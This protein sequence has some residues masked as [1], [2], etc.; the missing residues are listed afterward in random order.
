MVKKTSVTLPGFE[1][2]IKGTIPKLLI[3]SGTHGDEFE[4]IDLVQS[5]LKKYETMLP[6]FIYVPKVSPSAV[7]LKTR[8]TANGHDINRNFFSNSKDPEVVENIKL[9]K[10]HKFELMV[11]F[12][13]D[14]VSEDFYIYEQSFIPGDNKKIIDFNLQLKENG[15][16][17]LNGIDDPD[18]PSLGY[19]FVEGYRKFVAKKDEKNTGGHTTTWALTEGIIKQAL[20]P[21]IPGRLSLDR[22]RLIV[23]TF[24]EEVLIS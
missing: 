8:F 18:D 5:A 3:H 14:P 2:F 10:G 23:E 4:V 15:V 13:E 9:I 7:K 19:Q 12:H 1:Y 16:K 24:F 6:D 21:E 17:L 22:K 11:S 20:T